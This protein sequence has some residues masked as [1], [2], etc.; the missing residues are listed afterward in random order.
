MK[1]TMTSLRSLSALALAICTRMVWLRS[2]GTSGPRAITRILPS[3]NSA[4]PNGTTAQPMSIWP[5][6]RHRI[7]RGRAAG[8][9]RL[10]LDAELLDETER[11]HVRGGAVG[12]V[13]HRVLFGC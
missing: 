10:G 2:V 13:G 5:V 6:H 11:D 7:S 12:R 8:R 1:R 9:S 4:K 3:C